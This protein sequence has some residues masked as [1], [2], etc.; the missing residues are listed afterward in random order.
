MAASQW[1]LACSSLIPIY[2]VLHVS[3][4]PTFPFFLKGQVIR[5]TFSLNLS[6]NIV[7]LQVEKRCCPYYTFALNLSRNKFR[8]CKLWQHVA[9]SWPEFYFLQQTFNFIICVTTCYASQHLWLVNFPAPKTRERWWVSALLTLG[10][11]GQEVNM[12]E[13]VEVENV[14]T[15]DCEFISEEMS[16]SPVSSSFT[17]W[18]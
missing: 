10:I 3:H 16:R 6:R 2:W 1:H 18:W 13:V 4:V 5:A 12:A 11:F 7:A 14:E 9:Q 15:Q 17:S 8:C